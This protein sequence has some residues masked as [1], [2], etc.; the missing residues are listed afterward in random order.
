MASDDPGPRYHMK[1]LT[2]AEVKQKLKKPKPIDRFDG[3]L[4][5]Y[6]FI[7][8]MFRTMFLQSRSTSFCIIIFCV[9]TFIF[10]L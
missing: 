5:F 2:K 4:P 1:K 7:F 3:M 9:A 6:K 8:S 10:H